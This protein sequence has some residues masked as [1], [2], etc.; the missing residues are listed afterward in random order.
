MWRPVWRSV[1]CAVAR[2]Y[3]NADPGVWGGL[4]AGLM[5]P[6]LPTAYFVEGWAANSFHGQTFAIPEGYAGLSADSEGGKIYTV[7]VTGSAGATS[8][9]GT[10]DTNQTGSW[11]CTILHDDGT[12]GVYT[13]SGVTSGTLN[14]Q[15]PLRATT[16]AKP[17]ASLGGE[18]LGQHYGLQG[19][20]ALA[21]KIYATTK[22]EGYR[23]R[24]RSA[25]IAASGEKEE[26]GR[27]IVSAGAIDAVPS[28]SFVN[29]AGKSYW[30][31]RGVRKLNL[32]PFAV[33]G[34]GVTHT[35][36]LGG[37]SGYLE[38]FVSS[39][40]AAAGAVRVEV[41]IDGV[42]QYDQTFTELRRVIVPYTN[43][44]TGLLRITIAAS[45]STQPT[46]GDVRWWAYDR[47]ETW[48]DPVIDKNKNV[49]VLGDSWSARYSGGLGAE[50]QAA[51]TAAGGSGT[52]TTV[53]T[54]GHTAADGLARFDAD[55]APLLSVGD[56][57][58]IE[59]FVND[60]NALGS[61][62][63]QTWLDN[64]Y[65][66]GAKVQAL[67]AHPIYVMPLPTPAQAQ[68]AALGNYAERIGAGL[69]V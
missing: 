56:A 63:Y 34:Y 53:A 38:A 42:S 11:S 49:V 19:Y 26:W 24:Y 14:I 46:V 52:V 47:S 8:V 1:L 9:T 39:G 68:S 50:L 48:T 59:F 13:A 43:A 23:N 44:T 65:R 12:Y 18:F 30:T 2:K 22:R 55:V 62:G 17:L 64:L 67:G 21:R 40:T 41:L 69:P 28:N 37:S 4:Y 58:V 61:S 45:V 15:P 3:Q 33:A 20:K 54:G 7:N 5:S 25:W 60:C 29:A 6:S 66:I 32:G 35:A 16:T 51:I 36:S 31:G 57:C 27:I 10:F